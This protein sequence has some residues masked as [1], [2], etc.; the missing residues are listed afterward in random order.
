MKTARLLFLISRAHGLHAHLL[1]TQDLIHL[2][3]ARNLG[4][5]NDHLL[6]TDYSAELS[7]VTTTQ[8]TALHLEHIFSEK[9]SNRWYSLV[10]TSSGKMR[11]LLEVHNMRLEI[12]NLKRIVRAVHGKQSLTEEQLFTI[13]HKYQ[14]V[15]LHAL[16]NA[17]TMPEVTDLL[18]ASNYKDL[19]GW[20]DEYERY[21]NPI[22]LEAQLDKIYYDDFWSALHKTPDSREIW[23]LIGTQVDLRNVQLA[24]SSKYMKI[25]S[26]VLQKMIVDKGYRLSKNATSRLVGSDLQGLSG[27]LSWPSYADLAHKAVE[28]IGEGRIFEM[29]TLFSKY[30]QSYTEK[31]SIRNPNNLVYV[32]SYLDLCLREA[33][34]LTTLAIGKQMN[35]AN[36]KLRNLVS[37]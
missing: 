27:V 32:F 16:M 18:K 14:N 4:E 8:V 33:K 21:G 23:A 15:N 31:M 19:D 11:D 9:L 6:R 13:P 7:R 17:E 24:I 29:E 26:S 28:L 36:E 37:F 10:V 3:A 12:E 22:I 2:L 34:N 5:M 25:D 1:K 35:V 30:L 20:L